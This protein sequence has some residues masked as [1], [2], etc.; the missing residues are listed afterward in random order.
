VAFCSSSDGVV[1]RSFTVG[2]IPGVL[3]SPVSAPRDG[4]PVLVA[5]GSPR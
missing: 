1:D 3:W 4:S 5:G 2:D